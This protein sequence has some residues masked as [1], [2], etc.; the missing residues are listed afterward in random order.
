MDGFR[1]KVFHVRN[2]EH[3]SGKTKVAKSEPLLTYSSFKDGRTF[4]EVLL[5]NKKQDILGQE[6]FSVK[7]SKTNE[8]PIEVIRVLFVDNSGKEGIE[9]SSGGHDVVKIKSDEVA[10]RKNC[11]VGRL[12]GYANEVRGSEEGIRSSVANT[13]SGQAD[14]D[15]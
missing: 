3:S 8:F 14:N 4:K 10:W 13:I 2:Q 7:G 11:L 9:K 6:E 5:G 12:K 1:I 15:R